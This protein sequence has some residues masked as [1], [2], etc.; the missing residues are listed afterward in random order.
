MKLDAPKNWNILACCVTLRPSVSVKRGSMAYTFGMCS[1]PPSLA[2][3]NG[4]TT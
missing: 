3:R 2:G 1:V 4:I